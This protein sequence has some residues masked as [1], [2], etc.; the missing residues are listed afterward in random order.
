MSVLEKLEKPSDIKGLN[1]DELKSLSNDLREKIIE[2]VSNNGGH[3][4]SNLGVVDLTVALYK[5]FDFSKDKL[6]F[7]VGHQCYAHK[8][9]SD[10]KDKFSS[11]RLENGISGFPC[12][13]ESEYDAFCSG[14][15]GTSISAGL[16]YCMARD[17]LK[18]DY[19]V[20][21]VVG[22][23]SIS[24]GLNLEALFSSNVKPKNFIVI[25][26]DNGMSIS[27]N[28]SGFYKLISKS[29]TKRSYFRNLGTNG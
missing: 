2:T 5:E 11:I 4:S 3:L 21:C 6:I 19:T 10:R 16:G 22:D 8:I 15:A 23:G 12:I 29:T 25:L 14:H 13:G 20:I 17:K 7:D 26:N 27:K 1:I 18:E 28:K 24:N 9:L